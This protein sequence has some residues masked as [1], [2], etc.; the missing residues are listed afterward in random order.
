MRYQKAKAF[1]EVGNA[2]DQIRCPDEGVHLGIYKLKEELTVGSI[3][4][5]VRVI[6]PTK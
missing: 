1:G 2:K 6:T 5:V 4:D 3:F